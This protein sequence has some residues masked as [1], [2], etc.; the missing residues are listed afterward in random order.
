MWD[1]ADPTNGNISGENNGPFG[2]ASIA[3]GGF[4]FAAATHSN[5]FLSKTAVRGALQLEFQDTDGSRTTAAFTAAATGD[6]VFNV[7]DNAANAKIQI[8][9]LS[10]S[11]GLLS[12]RGGDLLYTEA[13]GTDYLFASAATTNDFN[14]DSGN[15]GV[16][17]KIA[18]GAI[19]ITG[20]TAANGTVTQKTD[21]TNTDNVLTTAGIQGARTKTLTEATNTSFVQIAVASGSFVGGHVE[22]TVHADDGTDFQARTGEINFSIVNKSGTETAVFGTA[23]NEAFAESAGASTLVLTF[24]ADTTPTN[25]VNLQA[26]ATSSLT[27][28]TLAIKYRVVIHSGTAT[29]T[30]Q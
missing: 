17:F 26:N 23:L 12:V 8:F 11:A 18:D 25:A 29:I 27:Q 30:P 3:L 7:Y 19:T 22:Y 28:S 2:Q 14:F 5:G 15:D 6:G 10:T 24:A 4:T 16:D 9:G 21:G 13:G 20:T 1:I